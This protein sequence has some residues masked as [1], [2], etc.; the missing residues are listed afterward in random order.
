L[1]NQAPIKEYDMGSLHQAVRQAM[2]HEQ[3][4]ID[5][6]QSVENFVLFGPDGS[7]LIFPQTA[8]DLPMT[9]YVMASAAAAVSA[10][11]STLEAIAKLE[12]R[13]D[14]LEP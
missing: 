10:S 11:D 3:A 1:N 9:G 14:V 5:Q 7:P 2:V 13:I 6:H 8:D 12:K 4:A